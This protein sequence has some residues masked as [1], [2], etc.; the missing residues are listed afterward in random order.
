MKPNPNTTQVITEDE[1]TDM[2]GE[3]GK[4]E[5]KE[6]YASAN[7]ALSPKPKGQNKLNTS[8]QYVN[9]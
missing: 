1:L 9:T 5:V 7:E 4:E 3:G 2:F 8:K 6:Y